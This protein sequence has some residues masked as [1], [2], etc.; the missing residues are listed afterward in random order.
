[1]LGAYFIS[2]FGYDA[3]IKAWAKVH[4][5]RIKIWAAEVKADY[6][7]I[8]LWMRGLTP[9]SDANIVAYE[10]CIKMGECTAN[11]HG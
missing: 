10:N 7:A 1:M 2:Y 11:H 9:R 8:V 6:D 3:D 5:D 4:W